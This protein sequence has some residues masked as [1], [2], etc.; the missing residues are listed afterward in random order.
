MAVATW[1]EERLRSVQHAEG[2]L[3]G[4]PGAQTAAAMVLIARQAFDAAATAAERGVAAQAAQ[5]D[6]SLYPASG[7]LWIR[8]LTASA[9]GEAARAE[10]DF[11][12]EVV[13]SSTAATVYARECAVLARESLAF[14]LVGKGDHA[15]ARE[16]LTAVDSAS[17]GHARAVLGLAIADG[18]AT[19]AVARVGPTCDALAGAGKRGERALVLAAAHGWAGRP[20][21]GLALVQEALATQW[22]DATG[23]SLPAEPMF[24]PLRAAAGH[25]RLAA[26]LASRAS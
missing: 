22:P 1:G 3:P 19:E 9:R 13:F 20:D 2:L 26:R 21:E 24:A 14:L 18:A 6:H 7:L 16:L 25:A 23:W 11:R 8:G 15:G 5:H 12:A 17:P 10:D 4:F